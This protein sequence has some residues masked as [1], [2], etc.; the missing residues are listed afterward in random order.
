ML[1]KTIER[2]K[3]KNRKLWYRFYQRK[4]PTKIEKIRKRERKYRDEETD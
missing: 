2:N 3:R 4:M 1:E